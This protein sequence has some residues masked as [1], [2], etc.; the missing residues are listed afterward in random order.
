MTKIFSANVPILKF[1]CA[2]HTG[3]E[4]DFCINNDLGMRNSKLL[5]SYCNI[6]DK[7]KDLGRLIKGW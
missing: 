4:V 1:S 6:N 5:G 2:I 7:V 3:I